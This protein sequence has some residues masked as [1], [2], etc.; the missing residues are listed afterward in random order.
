MSEFRNFDGEIVPAQ[1]LLLRQQAERH[2]ERLFSI[3]DD[4]S[5]TYTELYARA[6]SA[7]KGVRALGV[8]PGDRIGVFLPNCID[9][10]VAYFAA[11]IVGAVVVTINARYKVHELSYAIAFADI[12]LLFTTDRIDEHVNF[13]DL[14][15]E[16]LP[17]LVE[18]NSD[19]PL[20]LAKAPELKHVVLLGHSSRAPFMSME[21]LSSVGMSLDAEAAAELPHQGEVDD[22]AVTLFTSGT[23]SAPKACQLTHR[24]IYQTWVRTYPQEAGLAAGEKVWVPMPCFHV[25]GIGLA[26]GVLAHGACF[27][28]SIFHQP[29]AALNLLKEHRPEH[30]YPGFFILMLPILKEP[31]YQQG[32]FAQAKTMVAIAPYDTHMQ[33]KALM[34]EGITVFQLFG[35]TEAAGYVCFT[36]S[37]MPEAQRLRSSG[38]P[39]DGC[40][41]RVVNET[42]NTPIP[43][44]ED[45]EIQFRGANRFHSYYKNDVANADTILSGGW[46][47]TGDCGRL[48][49]DG[50]LIFRGRLKD[51]LKVGGEN[52]AAAE[53]EGY[54]GLHSA[55]KLAQVV[56]KDDEFYGDVPVAFVELM[57]GKTVG[58]EELIDFCKNKL[59]SF[60]VPKDVIFVEEWPMSA[61][62]IQKFRLKE[63]LKEINCF[64]I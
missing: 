19:Q 52:V 1:G 14:L 41:V 50:S 42:D 5:I 59:A 20:Q 29:R 6:L 55:V 64:F 21:Q 39:I 43:L 34:P 28:S 54:L 49:Q 22:I 23:T 18:G 62:K 30:L 45:G 15:F 48:A 44:G 3:I 2:G 35:M 58:R 24:S 57:P 36:P 12:K 51:M 13:G 37:A 63:R 61:T 10:M 9:F 27:L 16:T 26:A 17:D 60:K 33:M 11:H 47:K 56:G 4:E 46:V 7:A 38:M 40:E 53:I 32:D 31:D 8:K 25:G